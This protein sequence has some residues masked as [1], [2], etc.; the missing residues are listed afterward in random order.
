MLVVIFFGF[1]LATHQLDL[2]TA[3]L[4]LAE[5]VVIFIVILFIF[6][7]NVYSNISKKNK[8]FNFIKYFGILFFYVLIVHYY[9]VF[10]D[11]EFFNFI[12]T[13]SS[14]YD[15]FYETLNIT[16]LNDF[17]SFFKSYYYYNSFEF[18]MVGFVLLLGSLICVNLNFFSK[19]NKVLNYYDFFIVFDFFKDFS[20]FI[21]MRKQ[22]LNDQLNTQ[23]STRIFK[24]KLIY[25]YLKG[26]V[27]GPSWQMWC[28]V[29]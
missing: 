4:W 2:F 10:S 12:I 19:N 22:N 7:L 26:I 14:L 21:F 13:S 16:I 5:F 8:F 3:F 20:K 25:N 23:A 1:F 11:C 15:S 29:R 24:K 28:S 18:I 27:Y 9:S 17:F 6:F